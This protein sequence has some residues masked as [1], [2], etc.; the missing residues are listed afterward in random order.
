VVIGLLD[1]NGMECT[2]FKKNDRCG[3]SSLRGVFE[4]IH[5]V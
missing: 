4:C 3:V 2:P 5:Q 1:F